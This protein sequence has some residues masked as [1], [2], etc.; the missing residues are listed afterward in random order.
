MKTHM[1]KSRSRTRERSQKRKVH[2]D[3]DNKFK[4]LSRFER[5]PLLV[6]GV[7]DRICNALDCQIGNVV[8]FISLEGND[9]NEPSSIAINTALFGLYS[10]CSE[11]LVAENAEMLGSLEMYC[12]VPRHP[13]AREIQKI[14]RAAC[15]AAI[16][17]QFDT[18]E[19]HQGKY[20][21][22]GSRPVRG[23]VI[24]WPASIN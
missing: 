1:N 7:F 13:S 2:H 8:S 16:A 4:Y 18:E 24:E 14:G 5:Q 22:V 10:F 12:C 19:E 20:E 11:A 6:Q 3:L 23:Q 17:I 9:V 21:M 15:L